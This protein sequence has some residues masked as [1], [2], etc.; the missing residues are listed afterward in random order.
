MCLTIYSATYTIG[1]GAATKNQPNDS[2]RPFNITMPVRRQRAPP[3]KRQR[4]DPWVNLVIKSCFGK[5]TP[6]RVSNA[7]GTSPTTPMVARTP[8][9]HRH[10][11]R[12]TRLLFARS[13][14]GAHQLT[15]HSR[16]SNSQRL[17]TSPEHDG[18]E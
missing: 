18:R 9:K 10:V 6:R 13:L 5:A 7:T 3:K 16:Y 11:H 15:P 17:Q 8:A 2:I 12:S 1:N 4:M 14:L